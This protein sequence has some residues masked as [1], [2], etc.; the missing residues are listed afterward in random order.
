MSLFDAFESKETVDDV[1]YD[2]RVAKL[3]SH[4]RSGAAAERTQVKRR[5]ICVCHDH[6]DR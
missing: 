5:E 6:R 2:R 4:L 3:R 1:T